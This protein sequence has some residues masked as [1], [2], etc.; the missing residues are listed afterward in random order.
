M[1]MINIQFFLIKIVSNVR[2]NIGISDV[3]HINSKITILLR[4]FEMCSQHY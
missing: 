3:F 2:Y 1:G 4:V